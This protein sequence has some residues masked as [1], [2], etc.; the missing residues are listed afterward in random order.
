MT[1]SV[2]IPRRTCGAWKI[3]CVRPLKARAA[4]RPDLSD[5]LSP[6]QRLCDQVNQLGDIALIEVA[7]GS[8]LAH[9]NDPHAR[10]SHED[11]KQFSSFWQGHALR[12]REISCWH[13]A[14]L[15]NVDIEMNQDGSRIRDGCQ[16]LPRRLS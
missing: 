14:L 10:I 2:S 4:V 13:L 9:F 11:A 15:K 7:Q 16:R 8:V 6:L 5:R 3:F 12:V 1:A